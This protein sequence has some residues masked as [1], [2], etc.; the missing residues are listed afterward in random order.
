LKCVPAFKNLDITEFMSSKKWECTEQE[1][2]N[3]FS[4]DYE[5]EAVM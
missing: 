5:E 4:K 2:K 3:P 1:W